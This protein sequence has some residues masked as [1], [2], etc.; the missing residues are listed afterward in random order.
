MSAVYL[1]HF[2]PAYRHA[3]HY[4]GFAEDLEPRINAH[5]T[6]HGARLTQVAHDAGC[7]LILVRVWPG[8]DR[9]LERRIKNRKY[10]PRLCPICSGKVAL[11]LPLLPAAPAFVPEAV[12]ND[13]A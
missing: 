7:A 2:E 10:A 5:M 11:Q 8:G 3:R 12:T 6:G 1:L 13:G 9:T 4:T